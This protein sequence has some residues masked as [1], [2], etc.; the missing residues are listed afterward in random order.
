M[1]KNA[2]FKED[3]R[4]IDAECECYAC[5]NFSR[6]YIRHLF[7]AQEI[8][9]MRLAS[10]H[11]LHFY[12]ELVGM[13]REAILADQYGNWKKTFLDRYFSTKN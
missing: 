9:G 8:L 13:A 3:F 10:L 6:A 7:K 5:R 1:V 11:N 12:L 4:P 2:T